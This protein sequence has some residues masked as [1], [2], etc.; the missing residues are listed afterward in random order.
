MIIEI[1]NTIQNL[2]T[3]ALSCDCRFLKANTWQVHRRI[4]SNQ[5]ETGPLKKQTNKQYILNIYINVK[6]DVIIATECA[7]ILAEKQWRTT[8]VLFVK[9]FV[10]FSMYGSNHHISPKS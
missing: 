2:T 5:M 8:F 10:P 6:W 4:R 9:S 7:A 1:T 3:S